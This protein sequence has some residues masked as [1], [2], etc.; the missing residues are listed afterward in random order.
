M[1][2]VSTRSSGHGWLAV[3]TSADEICA[4]IP[5]GDVDAFTGLIRGL[6]QAE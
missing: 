3:A 1:A 2:S 6:D 5:G 4:G